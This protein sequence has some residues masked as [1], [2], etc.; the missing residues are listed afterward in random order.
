MKIKKY[1]LHKEEDVERAFWDDNLF[2]GSKEDLAHE[3][4]KID[5][6]RAE[7]KANSE[8]TK[9]TRQFE[10]KKKKQKGNKH[11]SKKKNITS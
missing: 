2:G 3:Q 6:A 10:R 1:N 8:K 7:M 9:R 5:K 11:G 4:F